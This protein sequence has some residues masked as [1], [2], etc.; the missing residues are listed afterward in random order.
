MPTDIG[1]GNVAGLRLTAD[2]LAVAGSLGLWGAL[3][4][5]AARALAA[6]PGGA[7]AGGL[8]GVGLHWASA[9]VH[10]LGHARAA[11]RTGH[12]MAGI[13]C[14][15]LLSASL[16]PPDEP[17]LPGAVH[18]RRALGGPLASLL[19][20]LAAAPVALVLRRR[21]G[22]PWWLAAFGVADNL[23][24]FTLGALLPLGFSDGSTLLRWRG[25]P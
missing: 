21:G 18:R 19:L 7:A 9:L 13:R 12:P 10:Q 11:R 22:L 2:S 20:A 8:I 6:P 4:G 3:S 15:A 14:F 5:V 25:K 23:L 1:L 16:Y 24:V 17:S